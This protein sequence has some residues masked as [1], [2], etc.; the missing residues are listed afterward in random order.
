MQCAGSTGPG[1]TGAYVRKIFAVLIVDVKYLLARLGSKID[2][3]AVTDDTCRH[4]CH[5][6]A[7]LDSYVICSGFVQIGTVT[8]SRIKIASGRGAES[9]GTR[10]EIENERPR[11]KATMR[12]KL[13]SRA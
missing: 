6:V 11:S 9:K 8:V 2:L 4:A 7:A 1:H 3:N 13:E 12:P 10:I 5:Y